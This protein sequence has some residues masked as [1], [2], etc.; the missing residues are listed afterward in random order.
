M[1][2]FYLN[3][4]NR[5]TQNYTIVSFFVSERGRRLF[6][7]FKALFTSRAYAMETRNWVEVSGFNVRVFIKLY[8]N[9]IPITSQSRVVEKASGA[10]QPC[11]HHLS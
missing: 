11:E 2:F 10:Q 8:L 6:L 1:F 4:N 3:N 5:K 9:R 7:I